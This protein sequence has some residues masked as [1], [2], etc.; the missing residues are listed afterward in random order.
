[1]DKSSDAQEGHRIQYLKPIPCMLNAV[2]LLKPTKRNGECQP[3]N[4]LLF[5][6]GVDLNAELCFAVSLLHVLHEAALVTL[7]FQRI[8]GSGDG[9][10]I[11]IC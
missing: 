8:H 4:E 6:V 2:G 7:T 5:R 1:M 3:L 9:D 11:Y 10:H